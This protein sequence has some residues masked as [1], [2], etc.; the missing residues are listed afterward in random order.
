MDITSF[1]LDNISEFFTNFK[2]D[3]TDVVAL[4]SGATLWEGFKFFFPDIQNYFSKKRKAKTI[5]YESLYPALKASDELFGKLESLSKEDFSTFISVENSNSASPE[6][7]QI[8]VCYL[9]SQ[10]WAT[11]EH[12][13]LQSNFISI[14]RLKKGNELLKFIETTES[15]KFRLLDRSKQRIIG[16]AMI[17]NADNK[18]QILSLYSFFERIEKDTSFAKWIYELREVF[19]SAKNGKARQRILVYGVII[20]EFLNHFDKNHRIARKREIYFNR[21][22]PTSLKLIRNVLLGKYLDFV[23]GRAKYYR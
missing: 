23:S 10:F 22:L 1:N 15:R 21:L 16:E 8:Y 2:V 11:L 9:V 3:V 4:L 5:F 12:I 14:T 7:N 20:F 6:H 17:I 19:T 13:R 18:F